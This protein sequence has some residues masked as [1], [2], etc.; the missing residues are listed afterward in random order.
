LLEAA[1]LVSLRR[2]NWLLPDCAA[3]YERGQAMHESSWLQRVM[4]AA[5][6]RENPA[7]AEAAFR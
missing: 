5:M 2:W 6:T 4:L 7:S 3:V 1:S